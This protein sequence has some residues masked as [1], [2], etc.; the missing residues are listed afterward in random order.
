MR[1]AAVIVGIFLACC[2]QA[3]FLRTAPGVYQSAGLRAKIIISQQ[4]PGLFVFWGRETPLQQ[5]SP[6]GLSDPESRHVFL[7]FSPSLNRYT[8]LLAGGRE[9]SIK[10]NFTMILGDIRLGVDNENPYV[11]AVS[12][13]RQ[14]RKTPEIIG[15]IG[16]NPVINAE[17]E[18]AVALL[19]A[20]QLGEYGD[21][22][23]PYNFDGERVSLNEQPLSVSFL[24][25]PITVKNPCLEAGVRFKEP[26][27]SRSSDPSKKGTKPLRPLDGVIRLLTTKDLIITLDPK[28][29]TVKKVLAHPEGEKGVCLVENTRY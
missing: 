23:K 1:A 13:N 3:E 14:Q 5:F 6:E 10:G 27:E 24:G 22:I 29:G 16:I 17:G 11:T 20:N 19:E 12:E 25:I 21:L 7:K 15:F 2:V 4:V 8:A 9:L 28:R 26:A 18:R